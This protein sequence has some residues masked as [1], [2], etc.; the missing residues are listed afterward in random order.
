MSKSNQ[1]TLKSLSILHKALLFGQIM[2]VAIAM[3]LKYSGN[4]PSLLSHLD[5]ILQLSALILSAASLFIGSSLFKK[6]VQQLRDSAEDIKN[7][8]T[9]YRSVCI[10]QWALI[11]VPSLF[12]ISCFI[13]VG[14]YAFLALAGALILWFALTAPSKMK[15]MLLLRLNEGEMENF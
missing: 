11:E 6:K 15:I 7:K 9:A 3:F 10:T 8:A 14:N 4:F 12:S 5:Q 1:S 2:F 13:L